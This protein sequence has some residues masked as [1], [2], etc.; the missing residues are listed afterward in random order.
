MIVFVYIVYWGKIY[1]FEGK[2][3]RLKIAKFFDGYIFKKI[4]YWF[5]Y[6]IRNTCSVIQF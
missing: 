1:N 3:H 4:Q 2:K 6:W 5:Q